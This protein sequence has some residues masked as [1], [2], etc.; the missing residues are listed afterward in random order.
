MKKIGV[1]IEARTS[2]S[3]LPNK[4]MLEVEGKPMLQH[5][6]ERLFLAEIPECVI[7]AT[8]KNS[9][10]DPIER[11][12]LELGCKVYRGSEHDVLT[13][14]LEAATENE[15]EIIVETPG[16]CPCIDPEILDDVI[17][18]Y[19]NAGIDYVS[20]N[21]RPTYCA[22]MDVQVFST[23][24]LSRVSRMTADPVDR[25][26]VSLFIYRNP[27]IFST[28]NVEAP[29]HLR[30]PEIKLLLDTK[31]DFQLISEVYK[32]LYKKNRIFLAKDII[33]LFEKNPQIFDIN[34]DVAR[35]VVP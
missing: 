16:D 26:H 12:G 7:I 11:L 27:E 25:E 13:R 2:S 32:I 17:S 8:T 10:D 18:A 33:D 20:N 19:L 14:V 15:I 6:V 3:R 1:I 9:A 22:G 23:E 31:E 24:V 5:M 34:K 28:M 29:E 30:F 21:L 4:V 35:T